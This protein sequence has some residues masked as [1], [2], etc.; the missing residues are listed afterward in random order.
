VNTDWHARHRLAKNAALEAR[1]AWHLEHQKRCACRPIP[2]SV[3][4]ALD[5]GAPAKASKRATSQSKS[6]EGKRAPAELDPRFAKVVSAYVNERGV[7]FGGK[8]FGSKA[9][10][11]GGKLFALWSNKDEFVV[12]LPKA[13]VEELVAQGKGRYFDTGAGRLMKEWLAV[14]DA[15]RSWAGLAGEALSFV[16]D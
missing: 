6:T 8:G 16:R 12:K 2:A 10:K 11:V 9:L 4:K 3:Q 5:A 7:T 13:R 15:P 1:I 14:T